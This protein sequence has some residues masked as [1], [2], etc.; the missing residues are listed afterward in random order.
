[1]KWNWFEGARRSA[2][3]LGVLFVAGCVAYAA[4]SDTGASLTYGVKKYGASP[5]LVD[6]CGMQDARKECA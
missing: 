1:M 4:L 5:V 3:A 6:K 2:V